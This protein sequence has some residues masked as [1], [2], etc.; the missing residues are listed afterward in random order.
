MKILNEDIKLQKTSLMNAKT[1]SHYFKQIDLFTKPVQ[2]LIKKEE[3]HKTI[4]GA[5]LSMIVIVVMSI[6]FVNSIIVYADRSKPVT[7][8][9]EVYHAEPNLYE[10]RPNNFTLQFGFQ[11]S[12][13]A[14]YIDESIYFVEPL[15]VSKSVEIINGTQQVRYNYVELPLV[16]C[17]KDIIKQDSLA[18]YFSHFD[19]STNYCIDWNT[20]DKINMQ[21]TFDAV[22]YQYILLKFKMCTEDNKKKNVPKC[23]SKEEIMK[24]LTHN[25]LSL[26]LSSY[27]VDLQT[28]QNP[29]IPKGEDLF[30]T[31]SSQ[32]FKEITIYLQPVTTYTDSGAFFQDFHY[33]TTLKYLHH[34]E[35]IDFNE[36]DLLANVAIRLHTIEQVN[37]RQYSRIQ[38][39][40]AELGGLWNVLFTIAMLIQIPYSTISYKLQI[41]NSL[42]NFDG[43]EETI[44]DDQDNYL[45]DQQDAP[46]INSKQ[47][48]KIYVENIQKNTL[49]DI[50]QTNRKLISPIK[51]N[52]PLKK[53]KFQRQDSFRSSIKS[54]YKVQQK[55][56]ELNQ[57]CMK[58]QNAATLDEDIKVKTIDKLNQQVKGFFQT[59][60]KKLNIPYYKYM[61]SSL[62][63]YQD[64][65]QIKQMNFSINRMEKSFDILYIIKKLHEIDKL[66][67]I[68]LTKEQIKLFD[69]LPKPTI[70][71]NPEKEIQ[72]NQYF[73]ILKPLKSNYQMALEAQQAYKEILFKM[74]DPINKHLIDCMDENILEFLQFQLYRNDG[75]Q[76]DDDILNDGTI[77]ET[78]QK[79][80]NS[81]QMLDNFDNVSQQNS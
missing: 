7:L 26:Q 49:N 51:Q 28:T 70:A 59:V 3:G 72:G 38:T 50:Q 60:S 15:L 41:I 14:T 19:L 79:R 27:Y 2:L 30:T 29:Y 65:Q 47:S 67:M 12:S 40:L 4:M 42:F 25:Y 76:Q 39:L 80:V 52:T 54:S 9:T 68:L 66:K 10:L 78:K 64:D 11:D 62:K 8:T 43:Q 37:Y 5:T 21:G 33:D 34:T 23:K 75:E 18:E 13:F 31:I 44:N 20:I 77:Q 73:S 53:S 24:K 74:H 6:F 36:E 32:I 17:S 57:Q 61:L 69:Y 63:L 1:F 22:N 56:Q 45:L 71:S 81:E 46:I 58:I 35:M 48:S 55:L 16:Q